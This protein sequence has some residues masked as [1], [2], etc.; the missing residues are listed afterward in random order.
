M[1]EYTK[2][3]RDIKMSITLKAKRENGKWVKY[4]Q[5][6]IEDFYMYFGGFKPTEFK[7][8]VDIT[9]NKDAKDFL[10]VAKLLAC[11]PL[12]ED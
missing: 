6:T 8:K 5:A 1:V 4:Q 7:L 3:E 11:W 9:T 12:K 10:E 2:K